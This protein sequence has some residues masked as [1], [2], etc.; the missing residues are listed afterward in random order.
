[1]LASGVLLTVFATLSLLLA[2]AGIWSVS[3]FVASRR[4]REM[5]IRLALG[6]APRRVRRALQAES[7]VPLGLGLVAGGL[8]ALAFTGWIRGLLFEVKRFD[9]LTVA[10]ALVTLALTTWLA[11]YLPAR[12][13]VRADL[14]GT[15]RDE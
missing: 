10:A 13:I 12:R 5:G 15:L 9:P 11:S 1:M 14:L 2:G 7:L 4:V 8:L 6:A 3:A